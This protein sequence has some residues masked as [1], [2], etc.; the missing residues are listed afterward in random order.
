VA[1]N[2]NEATVGGLDILHKLVS[3]ILKNSNEEKFRVLKVSNKTIHAKLMS[4]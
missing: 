4:L 3:N 1:S 2:P